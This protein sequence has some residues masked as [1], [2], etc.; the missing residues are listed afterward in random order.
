MSFLNWLLSLPEWAGPDSPRASLA[1]KMDAAI[2]K[3]RNIKT[4]RPGLV[5]P[6]LLLHTKNINKIFWSR[7][8]NQFTTACELDMISAISAADIAFIMSSSM[9]AWLLSPLEC[10]PQK[11][12]GWTLHFC[13][14]GWIMWKIS[15]PSRL[16]IQTHAELMVLIN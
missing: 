5:G 7:A 3:E 9:S 8:F 14:R 11:Q 4:W 10:S 13:F 15:V 12:N 2:Q 16:I 1:L 6:P